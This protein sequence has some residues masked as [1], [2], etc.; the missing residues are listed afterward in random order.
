MRSRQM[1]SGAALTAGLS[2]FQAARAAMQADK[3]G[4][5][6]HCMGV[7]RMDA[8]SPYF[9]GLD[10]SLQAHRLPLIP[11]VMMFAGF[12]VWLPAVDRSPILEFVAMGRYR[13]KCPTRTIEKQQFRMPSTMTISHALQPKK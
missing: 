12:H 1:P 10:Q 3:H 6:T 9:L 4:E 5:V 7:L 2:R 11:G 13:D 8:D